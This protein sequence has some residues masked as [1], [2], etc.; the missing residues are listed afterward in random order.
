VRRLRS[1]LLLSA[2]TVVVGFAISVV[3]DF[4]LTEARGA[5]AEDLIALPLLFKIRGPL[6]SPQEVV[7]VSMDA[8]STAVLN[9]PTKMRDWPRSLHARLI[10]QLVKQGASAIAVD[11]ELARQTKPAEDRGACAGD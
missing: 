7:I 11:L 3:L 4:A 1:F 2:V 8:T 5:A 6:P 9:L 10:Q